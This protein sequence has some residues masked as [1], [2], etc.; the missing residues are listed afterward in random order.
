MTDENWWK[1]T[2]DKRTF[3]GLKILIGFSDY[4]RKDT[5][6]WLTVMLN[7]ECVVLRTLCCV[8]RYLDLMAACSPCR[9]DRR[10]PYLALIL[11]VDF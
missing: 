3:E 11:H 4:F 6:S 8:C 2:V 10:R 5:A 9:S 1:L 7:L